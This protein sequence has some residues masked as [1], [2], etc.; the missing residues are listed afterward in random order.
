MVDP[1]FKSECDDC[2]AQIWVNHMGQSTHRCDYKQNSADA[3]ERLAEVLVHNP[4]YYLMVNAWIALTLRETAH[5]PNYRLCVDGSDVDADTVLPVERVEAQTCEIAFEE[6]KMYV[7][8]SPDGDRARMK[9]IPGYRGRAF[10]YRYTDK[11]SESWV[12]DV[13]QTPEKEWITDVEVK[14]DV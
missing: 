7:V 9:I 2:G 6:R 11:E 14:Y 4:D 8:Y 5:K 3:A 13:I 12:E 1:T 10:F